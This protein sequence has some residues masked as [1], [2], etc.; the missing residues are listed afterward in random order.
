MK[1]RR[2]KYQRKQD[3]ATIKARIAGSSSRAPRPLL[4][5]HGIDESNTYTNP[6]MLRAS[7]TF[8]PQ[9]NQRDW[10]PI[11]D[12]EQARLPGSVAWRA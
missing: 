6:T 9:Q 5:L 7:V 12:E 1:R 2:R 10:R 3:L 4:A 11:G 8:R